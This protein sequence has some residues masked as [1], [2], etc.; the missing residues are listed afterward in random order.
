M[1]LLYFGIL[2]NTKGKKSLSLVNQLFLPV[3]ELIAKLWVYCCLLGQQGIGINT[4]FL[5]FHFLL[6]ISKRPNY[7]YM[8]EIGLHVHID[9]KPNQTYVHMEGFAHGLSWKQWQN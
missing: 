6:H 9:I 7:S 1:L 2:S 5:W 4:L 8:N 3:G